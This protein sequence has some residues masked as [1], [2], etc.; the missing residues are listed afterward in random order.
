MNPEYLIL[1]I[2]LLSGK[3]FN[4]SEALGFEIKVVKSNTARRLNL[5]IDERYRLP[6]LTIPRFCSSRK[7]LAFAEQH[8]DWIQNMLA[9]LPQSQTF[10]DGTEI[11]VAGQLFI[12]AHNPAQRGAKIENGRLTI[13]GDLEFL[14]RRVCGFLKKYA[15]EHLYQRSINTA[16][17]IGCTV[18]RVTIKET[19]SRW[20]SCS[21]KNNI[22]YNWRIILAPE[23]VIDYLVCHEVSHLKHPDHSTAFWQCVGELCPNWKEGRQWLKVKGKDLYRWL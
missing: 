21:T 4:Y 6:V 9:R 17:K 19:K 1:K 15:G 16:A 20:G 10:A 2:T 14:H 13:G 12:V 22:N 8:R 3:T 23:Y 11:S 5:R 7:A 18:H